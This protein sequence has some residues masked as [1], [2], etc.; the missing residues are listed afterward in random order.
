MSARSSNV[1]M[2]DALK[3]KVA[4]RLL[5]KAMRGDGEFYFVYFDATGNKHT[6]IH[7]TGLTARRWLDI[8]ESSEK[9][10]RRKNKKPIR[11][12]SDERWQ[13]RDSKKERDEGLQG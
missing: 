4:N 7:S 3:G 9:N 10:A 12:M 6:E 11:R 13:T 1:E 2:D 5:Q 8:L